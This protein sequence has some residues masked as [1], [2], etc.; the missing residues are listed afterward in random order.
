M[1]LLH[2]RAQA[3]HPGLISPLL[4]S[5]GPHPHPARS[6][7][8][9][10]R[11]PAPLLP[12]WRESLLYHES[13]LTRRSQ[14]RQRARATA[15]AG[16]SG[17]LGLSPTWAIASPSVSSGNNNICR[18]S[19]TL[20]VLRVLLL[21]LCTYL[22]L[23]SHHQACKFSSATYQL[24]DLASSKWPFRTGPFHQKMLLQTLPLWW[25]RA[26][27]LKAAKPLLSCS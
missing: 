5:R 26:P 23:A 16:S 17:C 6:Q 2:Q 18:Q 25:A 4:G 8:P 7:H 24:C 22:L 13:D 10:R 9:G 3:E 12:H 15:T 1:F 27:A 11:E 20:H 21:S 14:P 19:R